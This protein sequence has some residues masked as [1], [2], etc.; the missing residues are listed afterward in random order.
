MYENL[1]KLFVEDSFLKESFNLLYGDKIRASFYVDLSSYV[2]MSRTKPDFLSRLKSSV[3]A[4]VFEKPYPTTNNVSD[5]WVEVK[6][7]LEAYKDG[8]G[9]NS[10]SEF[11]REAIIY[12]ILS[13]VK[14][15]NHRIDV[16]RYI[17]E[18][19][20]AWDEVEEKEGI[21]FN[22][23]VINLCLTSS[24]SKIISLLP[25]SSAFYRG[26]SL[27]NYQLQPSVFRNKELSLNEHRLVNDIQVECP[28]EFV[29]CQSRFERLVKMQHYGL[30]TRLLDVTT[31]PLVALYFACCSNT[32][33]IG[34]LVLLYKDDN[35]IRY[36]QSDEVSILSNLSTLDWNQ[37]YS[38]FSWLCGMASGNYNRAM[39]YLLSN[40]QLERSYV[41][42]IKKEVLRNDYFVY[43]LKKNKRI[44]K[45][46]GAF[47]LFGLGG[48]CGLESQ[49]FKKNGKRIIILVKGKNNILES[50]DSYGINEATLFP[51]IDNVAA[52]LKR[53][54]GG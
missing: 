36:S 40:V 24:F 39:K 25:G 41:D 4:P 2:T 13:S 23:K 3:L 35:L 54:Y 34:E 45:Q 28:E 6:A 8:L 19:V 47:V 1:K 21:F 42:Y 46:D 15:Q 12:W 22:K 52:Y 10:I 20:S 5:K 53:K 44:A 14:R 49:R 18:K 50:L 38:L 26:H 16:L 32:S 9:N 7:K 30:P 17:V 33:S 29:D 43:A 27:V 11:E 31:N 51:E 37:K 48:G